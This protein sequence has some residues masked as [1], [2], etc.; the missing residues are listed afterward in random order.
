MSQ[1]GE[2]AELRMAAYMIALR[3]FS[4]EAVSEAVTSVLEGSAGLNAR[5]APTPPELATLCRGKE[6]RLLRELERINREVPEPAQLALTP[7]DMARRQEKARRASAMIDAAV[8]HMD[9]TRR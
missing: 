2:A 8:E 3:N 5:F 1:A 9:V 7:E 6:A 4:I